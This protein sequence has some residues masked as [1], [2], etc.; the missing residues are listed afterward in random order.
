MSLSFL[1]LLASALLSNCFLDKQYILLTSSSLLSESETLFSGYCIVG[2]EK[3]FGPEK[4]PSLH[5]AAFATE[6]IWSF[7]ERG[8]C[9][10]CK[11]CTAPGRHPT[12]GGK[13]ENTII[14][15]LYNFF[16]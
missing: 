1:E 13:N 2:G 5:V 10:A 12:R 15:F 7:Q 6:I 4:K 11:G 14:Y 3:A 8:P 9:R 16:L